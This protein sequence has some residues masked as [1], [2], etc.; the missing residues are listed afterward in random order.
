LNQLTLFE[1]TPHTTIHI[2]KSHN[3]AN[4]QQSQRT[5]KPTHKPKLGKEYDNL[6]HGRQTNSSKLKYKMTK[7]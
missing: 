5:T 2:A 7:K 1:A 6:A 4:A 3:K